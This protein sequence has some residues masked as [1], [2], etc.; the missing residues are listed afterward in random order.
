MSKRLVATWGLLMSISL[1]TQKANLVICTPFAGT[2]LSF[3]F[4]GLNQLEL[5]YPGEAEKILAHI[6][7]LQP[8]IQLPERVRIELLNYQMKVFLA[9]KERDQAITYLEE[10]ANAS[11][12]LGS[13]RHLQEAFALFR[14]MQTIWRHE[15]QVQRLTDLFLRE[16]ALDRLERLL[17]DPPML[18]R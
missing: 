13:E 7:G 10:A 15:P 11:F 12:S 2:P 3:F 18:C 17:D 14:Q 9:R 6:D 4:D 1:I 16:G 8:K 5:G